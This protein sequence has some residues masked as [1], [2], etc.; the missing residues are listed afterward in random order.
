MTRRSLALAL[1]PVGSTA[2]QTADRSTIRD[3]HGAKPAARPGTA[4]PDD[5]QHDLELLH[6]VQASDAAAL[7]ALLQKYWYPLVAYASRLLSSED[8]AQDVVQ[9]VFIRLWERR[10][11]LAPMSAVRPL[12]YRITRNIALNE[13]R[14]RRVRERWLQASEADE[15]RRVPTP[16]QTMI[17][18]ELQVT[19]ERAIEALPPRRREAFLL[20]RFHDM[21]HRQIAGVMGVSV[22][23]VANQVSGALA[24]L[25]EALEPYLDRSGRDG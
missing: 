7:D 8:G 23:T 6:R 18:R 10:A 25:R 22:Q 3:E 4:A 16:M 21:S 24:D 2:G 14:S 9:D 19:V 15:P 12:L 11:L 20:A 17:A 1:F 13:L 5:A